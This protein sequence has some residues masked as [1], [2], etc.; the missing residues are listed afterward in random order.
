MPYVK[1]AER[2]PIDTAMALLPRA[3]GGAL[4]LTLGQIAYLVYRV[5]REAVRA[6]GGNFFAMAMVTGAVLLALLRY[7]FKDVM[8]YEDL[9]ERENGGIE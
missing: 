2:A 5:M 7:V 8:R 4:A 6:N 1:Q 3:P 9:K